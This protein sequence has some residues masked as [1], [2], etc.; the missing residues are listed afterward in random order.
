M[1]AARTDQK[2]VLYRRRGDFNR[3]ACNH[4]VFAETHQGRRPADVNLYLLYFIYLFNTVVSYFVFAYKSVLLSAFQRTDIESNIMS[5]SYVAMYILQVVVLLAFGNYYVYIVFLPLCTL[6][7]NLVRS[8][9]VNK[10]YPDYKA[11]NTLDDAEKRRYSKISA[12]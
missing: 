9:Y 2:G 3:R 12:P 1:R 11:E 10:K 7:I 8:A 4:A 5:V 6:T